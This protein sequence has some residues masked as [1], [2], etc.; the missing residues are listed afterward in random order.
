MFR[1]DRRGSTEAVRVVTVQS[2]ALLREVL[3]RMLDD[4]PGLEGVGDAA[5]PEAAVGLVPSVTP[6]AA[7]VDGDRYDLEDIYVVRR[8]WPAAALVLLVEDPTAERID[9]Y[10]AYG[11]DAFVLK[12]STPGGLADTVRRAGAHARRRED[13]GTFG[14]IA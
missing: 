3:V 10:R 9:L 2:Q 14:R 8:A 13:V 5:T 7:L 1:R 6:D 4:T 12:S 11:A